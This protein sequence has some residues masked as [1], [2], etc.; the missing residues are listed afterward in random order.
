MAPF[1]LDTNV[2]LYAAGADHP[3]RESCQ[4]V[5]E[6][7]AEGSL[8][9]VTSAEVVQEIL[10]VLS[11]RGLRSEGLRLAASVLALF[12][13]LLPVRRAE[14]A[15]ALLLLDRYPTLNPRDAVHGATVRVN[16]LAGIVTADRHF[17]RIEGVTPLAPSQVLAT[18]PGPGPA[19]A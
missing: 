6:R 16:R 19:P 4:R 7:V 5:L 13:E 12:P 17:E 3:H 9:A 2:F 14:I 18:E 10:Y 1:F 15:E 8:S 11:R